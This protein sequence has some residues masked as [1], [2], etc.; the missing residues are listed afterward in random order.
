[1]G[2]SSRLATGEGKVG[3]RGKPRAG[4]IRQS[5]RRSTCKAER[6][7]DFTHQSDLP[8]SLLKIAASGAKSRPLNI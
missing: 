1:M 7:S 6:G 4:V 2:P 8:R 5:R 3:Q